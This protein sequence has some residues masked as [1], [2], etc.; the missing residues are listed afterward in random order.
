MRR[1]T[2]AFLSLL[3]PLS[4][5]GAFLLTG[6]EESV[7]THYNLVA[8]GKVYYEGEQTI[9]LKMSE[10]S[11]YRTAFLPTISKDDVRLSGVLE[12]K[13]VKEV[14]YV[15]SSELSLTLQGKVNAGRERSEELGDIEISHK[16]LGND[17][18]GVASLYVD[19]CPKMVA[20]S[21]DSSQKDSLFTY[22]SDFS[23]PYGN[24]IEENA[25]KENVYVPVEGVG[26]E[27]GLNENGTLRLTV[28]G[29]TPF[30]Y[31]GVQYDHPIA[32]LDPSM[33]TFDKEIYVAVGVFLASAN[34]Y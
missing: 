34:L 32:R 22:V 33:T 3:I 5:L 15:S 8:S 9:S 1:Q 26:I 2:K 12:G 4:S 21:I 20:V 29:F 6:C 17:A 25:K 7:E 28:S 18:N 24:F 31:E 11:D 16:A 19:F 13:T 23:L 10:Y 30:E 14:A 27:V